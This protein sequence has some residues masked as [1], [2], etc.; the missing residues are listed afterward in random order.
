MHQRSKSKTILIV[1]DDPELRDLLVESCLSLTRLVIEAANGEEAL[2]LF[3]SH[4]IDAIL[5]DNNMPFLSGMELL[6][7]IREE[8]SDVPFVF[9]TGG[10]SAGDAEKAKARGAAKVLSKPYKEDDV[11]AIL[12]LMI[13]P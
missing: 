12:K 3:H 5:S 7:K 8:G 4:K 1:E 2:K 9:L 13:G 10:M 11:I 6:Q